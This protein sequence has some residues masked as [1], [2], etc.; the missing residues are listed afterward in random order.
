[1]PEFEGQR[2]PFA[3]GHELSVRHGAYSTLWL[4]AR[5]DETVDAL[6][7]LATRYR[8]NDE[9]MVRLLAATL[10]RIEAAIEALDAGGRRLPLYVE[11]PVRG[12]HLVA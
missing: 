6:R 12:S 1:V 10:A 3:P 7:S 11:P 5:A 2:P 9:P 8:E 4:T